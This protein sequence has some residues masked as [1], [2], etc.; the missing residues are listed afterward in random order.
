MARKLLHP[1][2]HDPNYKQV[3]PVQ[4]QR[5]LSNGT[6]Y[7]TDNIGHFI[8]KAVE[9]DQWFAERK[10]RSPRTAEEI[11]ERLVAGHEEVYDT[12]WYAKIRRKPEPKKQQARRD[13]YPNGRELDCGHVVFNQYE[14]MSAS[15]GSS[16]EACY[17]RMS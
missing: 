12:D 17:D 9:R 5:M 1:E 16:C 6:W 11:R 3:E 2:I 4:F 15:L 7:D 13:D 14:V 10:N 8:E